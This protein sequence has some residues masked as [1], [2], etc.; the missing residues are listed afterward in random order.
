MILATIAIPFSY[1]ETD[2]KGNAK[3]GATDH[4]DNKPTEKQ[5]WKVAESK[6]LHSLAKCI[7]WMEC[8]NNDVDF[9]KFTETK[10]WIN[11]TEDQKICIVESEDLGSSL[12]DY[13]LLDCY[14]NSNY[15]NER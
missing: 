5:F 10:A 2:W 13:E 12:A 3:W 6:K 7:D 4:K 11:A 9:D 15:Y 1:A 14:K 8:K